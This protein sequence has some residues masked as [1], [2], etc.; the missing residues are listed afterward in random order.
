M[1]CLASYR[2]HRLS[3]SS[4]DARSVSR[5]TD[6]DCQFFCNGRR[7]PSMCAG[8]S[9]PQRPHQK[10]RRRPEANVESERGERKDYLT[11]RRH[12]R[13]STRRDR[14]ARTTRE[15]EKGNGG[16]IHFTPA[17]APG[18]RRGLR[19]RPSLGFVFLHLRFWGG[20]GVA[21]RG[22]PA[23]APLY[24]TPSYAHICCRQRSS[25]APP[26]TTMNFAGRS[27][28]AS[29]VSRSRARAAASAPARSRSCR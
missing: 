2:H 12:Q 16:E 1:F 8:L 24:Y 15:R 20:V 27:R 5:R 7:P 14:A 17:G 18:E 6:F 4:S 10:R 26:A 28:G 22:P 9:S 19:S 29:R 3:E 13:K 25:A 23:T 21:S 11:S